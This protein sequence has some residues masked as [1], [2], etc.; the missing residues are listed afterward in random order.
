MHFLARIMQR[1]LADLAR[2]TD[3]AKDLVFDPNPRHFSEATPA[4]TSLQLAFPR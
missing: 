1:K 3:L 2:A 4:M